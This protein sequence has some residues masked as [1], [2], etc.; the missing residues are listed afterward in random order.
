MKK[1]FWLAYR[2]KQTGFT[3]LELLI[4][5]CIVA[6]LLSLG[7][8]L[9]SNAIFTQKVKST[10]ADI[11]IALLNARSEAIKRNTN[12]DIIPNV[13]NVWENGWNIQVGGTILKT[14]DPYDD[15]TIT[16]P[17]ITVTYQRTGRLS[18]S[19]GDYTV[20]IA[21]SS[22]VAMRCVII[23]ANGSPHIEVDT[24]NNPLNGCN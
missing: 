20:Y 4:T 23:S 7:M 14:Q 16:G 1:Q 18:N 6:V 11:R 2:L 3:L 19:V 10:T 21:N 17:N 12:V 8:P 13:A 24:D 9:M 5:L 15:L 22:D